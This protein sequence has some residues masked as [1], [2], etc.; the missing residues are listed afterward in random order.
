MNIDLRLARQ[1]SHSLIKSL[2]SKGILTEEDLQ[3]PTDEFYSKFLKIVKESE[4]AIVTDYR[5]GIQQEAENYYKSK[6]YDYA[7]LFYATFFEHSLNGLIKNECEKRKINEKTKTDIIRSVDLYG[8]LTW[9]PK[10]LGFKE[11]NKNH[12]KT[13]KRL[14]EQRNS[15][16]HYKWN[17]SS[18]DLD[19]LQ[20]DVELIEEFK[21][22]KLAVKYMKSYES[23]VY[24]RRSKGKLRDKLR[25]K[26]SQQTY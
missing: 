3:L 15:F 24:F 17:P 7:R 2:F 16:V 1:V 26:H 18:D 12:I 9:L 20:S 8:K 25:G 11:F 22:I 13:I 23:H 21:K 5:G 6:H 19:N 10:L 14:A 4:V